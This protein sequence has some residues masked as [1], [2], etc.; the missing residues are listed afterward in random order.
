M[1]YWTEEFTHPGNM[2]ASMRGAPHPIKK[3]MDTDAS[4]FLVY[5]ATADPN[6]PYLSAHPID[7]WDTHH[8]KFD[9][10][11]RFGDSIKFVDLPN[12]VRLDEVAQYF[13]AETGVQ[14][15]GVMVCGSPFETANDPNLGQVFESESVQE[16]HLLLFMSFPAYSLINLILCTFAK[17]THGRDTDW[18][19]WRNREYVWTTVVHD[20]DNQLRQR[21]AWT[22]AQLLVVARGAIGVQGSHT[23]PFLT[24]Y[25]IF[26]KNAFGNYRDVLK[27]ISYSPLMAEN[28]S[29]LQS[30]SAAY[31][32]EHLDKVAFAD[33]NFAREIM[34]L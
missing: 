14:G 18:N 7:R 25:D 10:L 32:W 34:Q 19:L 3:W 21:V 12:N 8:P 29:F 15:G 27:E 24:Y 9:K 13:G 33:E 23:E 22:L 20:S 11:G 26:T 31:M 16:E 17:V 30:K 4:A 28:L 1:S 5:P 2:V 6:N